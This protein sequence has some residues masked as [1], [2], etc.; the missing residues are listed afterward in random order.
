[1]PNS[2][3]LSHSRALA[4]AAAFPLCMALVSCA[5]DADNS[6]DSSEPQFSDAVAQSSSSSSPTSSTEQ[7]ATTTDSPT[8]SPAETTAQPP[9]PQET[10]VTTTTTQ[11]KG[12]CS[13]SAFSSLEP[14]M[15]NILVSDCDGEWAHFGKDSTDWTAWARFND[16]AWTTIEPIGVANS[17]LTAP[18]YDVDKWIDQGAPSFVADNMRRCD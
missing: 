17:G 10:T 15:G 1:M 9:A 3:K 4:C 8:T 12:D 6:V 7:T 5:D 18:C 16:G 14:D 2:L 13:P 11:A